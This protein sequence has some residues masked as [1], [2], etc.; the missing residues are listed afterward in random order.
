MTS[1]PAT[2]AVSTTGASTTALETAPPTRIDTTRPPPTDVIAGSDGWGRVVL[3]D[4]AIGA[5]S[6]DWPMRAI[7]AGPPRLV[8]VGSRTGQQGRIPAM[9]V[10]DDGRDWEALFSAAT[11]AP[12]ELIDVTW[13]DGGFVAVGAA[14]DH[15]AVWLSEDGFGW[16]LVVVEASR[17]GGFAR[18]ES[19]VAV[20]GGLFAAGVEIYV[21]SEEDLG[22]ASPEFVGEDSDAAVWWS[23]DG[24]T[25]ERI[26]DP[27]FGT[28]GYQPNDG[29]EA[30]SRIVAAA[31]AGWGVVFAGYASESNPGWDYPPESSTV[32]VLREEWER[33]NLGTDDQILGVAAADGTSEASGRAV[34]FGATR[35]DPDADAVF[36]VSDDGQTWG[37]AGGELSGIGASDGIQFVR[38]VIH[39]P[40][41]GW[42]AVGSDEK[43]FASIG[44]AAVWIAP[45]A[46]PMDW[47]RIRHDDAVFGA[48]RMNPLESMWG[49][50]YWNDRDVVIVGGEARQV[51]LTDGGSMCCEYFP[52]TWIWR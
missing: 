2:D 4:D 13:H 14:D 15:A 35:A 19:V 49:V 1:A 5:V 34:I 43:E 23:A 39:V 8:A 38:D 24:R 47:S 11:L 50:T 21:P 17:P 16:E 7:A 44:A 36:L 41:V 6:G 31:D 10:S 27:V 45:D 12:G 18:M 42:V 20:A 51:R 33:I 26:E 32:W 37:R 22:G 9:W 30:N 46:T 40:G 48:L 52:A 28:P 29:G 3:G 25:W